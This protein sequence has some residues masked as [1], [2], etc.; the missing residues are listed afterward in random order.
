MQL[1]ELYTIKKLNDFEF[2]ITPKGKSS[3]IYRYD[4]FIQD[5]QNLKIVTKRAK[6]FFEFDS[7]EMRWCLVTIEMASNKQKSTSKNQSSTKVEHMLEARKQ[8]VI[9]YFYDHVDKLAEV[10]KFCKIEG[11]QSF[12]NIRFEIRRI[13]RFDGVYRV[14]EAVLTGILRDFGF[15]VK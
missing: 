6:Y 10:K 7:D 5:G 4:E 2:H 12:N 3:R 15:V 14:D 11:V 13:M 1:Y 9:D 8:A